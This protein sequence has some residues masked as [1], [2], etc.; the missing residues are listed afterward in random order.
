MK[1]N[2]M[3]VSL[4]LSFNF[5][6]AQLRI[7]EWEVHAAYAKSNYVCAGNQ[8]V[9]C[10][11]ASGIFSYRPESGE[12]ITYTKATNLSD[13]NISAI[14]YLT[15][16]NSLAVAY[17]NGNLDIISDEKLT[18]IPDIKFSK[19]NGIKKTNQL[20]Y[21]NNYLYLA[22]AFG[23]VKVNITKKEIAETYY[24]GT[25]GTPVNVN[26][27][28]IFE[29]YF[30]AATDNGIFRCP[31]NA[32]NPIDFRNWTNISEAVLGKVRFSKLCIY[33]NYIIAVKKGET[34]FSDQIFKLEGIS[35]TSIATNLD[36]ISDIISENNTLYIAENYT[37]Y[38]VENFNPYTKRI[39]HKANTGFQTQKLAYFNQNI[40]LADASKGLIKLNND[41]S[42]TAFVP[43]SPA[44]E[45]AYKIS[46]GENSVIVSA[47]GTNASWNNLWRFGQYMQYQTNRWDNIIHWDKADYIEVIS[48]PNSKNNLAAASWGDGV[49]IIEDHKIIAHFNEK[50]STLQSQSGDSRYT[51]IGGIAY[52]KKR[53]LWVS[54]ANVPNFLSV[55][56][57]SGTWIS[58]KTTGYLSANPTTG[59]VLITD[60]NY[61]WVLLPRIGSIFIYDYNKTLENTA[62]DRA[63]IIRMT[64]SK[65]E[66]ISDIANDMEQDSEGNIWVATE[67]GPVVFYYPDGIFENEN[68][69]ASR[70]TVESTE[71]DSLLHYLLGAESIKTLAID[72]ANR[73]WFGTEKSGVYL[74]GNNGKSEIHHFDESN[75]P[76]ISN[77]LVSVGINHGNGEVFFGTD[78]G[79][80]S[81]KG[82]ATKTEEFFDKV[83][84]YPNPVP[85]EYT[86]DI[87]IAGLVKNTNVK[88]TDIAGNLVYE[89]KA[90]GGQSVWNGIDL[91]GN[92]IG[93]GIYLVFLV[94]ET[95]EKKHVTKFMVIR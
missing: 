57:A 9:Y 56:T 37:I 95:G 35:F 46:S 2:L 68:F 64:D 82:T 71:N 58:M 48:V 39:L 67:K 6:T 54:N 18:N 80:V 33:N 47:G 90:T 13:N 31:T 3:L 86:A 41:L 22:T 38:A 21:Y 83:Y 59:K 16:I 91:N 94:S 79:I 75:S 44:T 14:Q 20:V 11:S 69:A 92:T 8:V 27:L 12:L 55:Y 43:N 17:Q 52:D 85:P 70:I 10:A 76:L 42:E 32:E 4:I 72:G 25:N 36:A 81:Y 40:W 74:I 89:A 15:E 29:N 88:I 87:T 84:V 60:D 26:N 93:S 1:L 62:D 73:I 23:I 49:S 24:I 51:R 77:T 45:N 28:L 61:I 63:R 34:S 65:G 50:N 19:I 5:I 30:Y 53:N 78:M 7:G 66:L